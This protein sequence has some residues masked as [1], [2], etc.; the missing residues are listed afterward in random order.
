MIPQ[1]VKNPASRDGIGFRASDIDRY[2]ISGNI[3]WVMV[4]GRKKSINPAIDG[5]YI[6]SDVEKAYEKANDVIS[7]AQGA[8]NKTLSTFRATIKND[9]TSISSASNRV[10]NEAVKMNTT[11]SQTIETLNSKGME[12][13]ILNAERLAAALEAISAIKPTDVNFKFLEK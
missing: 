6:M 10:S 12:D 9:L 13:A 3:G 4:D 1:P 2:L 7:L 8:F 11:Y 5:D